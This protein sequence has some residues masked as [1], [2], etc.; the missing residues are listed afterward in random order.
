MAEG[1]KGGN[2]REGVH[3]PPVFCAKSAER[4]EKKRDAR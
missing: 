2:E 4:I 1:A 3:P